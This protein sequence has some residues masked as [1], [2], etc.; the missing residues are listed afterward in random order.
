MYET[1]FLRTAAVALGVYGV[2]GL[3]I[4]AAILFVGYSTFN[5]VA[6]LQQTLESE[7]L[8][9]VQSIRTASGTLRDTAGATSEFERS[10][11][12]A[13]SAADQSSSLANDS[14]GTF[15]EM[16]SSV[17]TLNV[18]GVEPL[19]GLGP[20]FDRS[21][22]Q[23]QQLAI[24]LGS[25]REAL[26]QNGA[27]VRRVGRDLSQLQREMDGVAASLSQPGVLGLSTQSMLPFQLAF[28]GLC[29]LV[30]VQSAFSIV[31]GVALYRVPRSRVGAF[32]RSEPL[33][34]HSG[35]QS[36]STRFELPRHRHVE[37]AD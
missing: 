29:L 21:A 34:A 37:G 9:L 27:D 19:A 35:E 26:A 11:A 7:R 5:Q 30:V 6:S 33:I 15:R 16:G 31:A 12:N 10:I 36:P 2:F 24:T 22:D 17:R 1:R 13:R 20:Q 8:A 14:A 32:A 4:A 25:T 18:L 23:L 3:I 28:Y